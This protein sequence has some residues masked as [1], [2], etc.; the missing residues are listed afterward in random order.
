MKFRK[1]EIRRYKSSADYIKEERKTG[2]HIA[3]CMG[4]AGFTFIDDIAKFCDW[5]DENGYRDISSDYE[6]QL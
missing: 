4:S 5:C 2:R 3:A 6:N 1:N